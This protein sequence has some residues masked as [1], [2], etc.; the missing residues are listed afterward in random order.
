MGKEYKKGDKIKIAVIDDDVNLNHVKDESKII[1]C[2]K[3]NIDNK[4]DRFFI[5]RKRIALQKH[6]IACPNRL[7]G[8]FYTIF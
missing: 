5:C 1:S 4:K 7:Y 6:R 3:I 2:K 8:V